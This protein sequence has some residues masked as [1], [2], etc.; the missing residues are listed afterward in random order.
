[1]KEHP[2]CRVWRT[3]KEGTNIAL[4]LEK[5][6]S[7]IVNSTWLLHSGVCVLP[8][9][10]AVEQKGTQEAGERE[11]GHTHGAAFIGALAVYWPGRTSSSAAAVLP[12]R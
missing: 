6:A 3:K 4:S 2:R 9:V 10:G 5:G 11:H 7:K 8:K 1:M 12:V